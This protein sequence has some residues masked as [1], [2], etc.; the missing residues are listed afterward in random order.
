MDWDEN[1]INLNRVFSAAERDG[2]TRVDWGTG[3]WWEIVDSG[4]RERVS[5]KI[6]QINSP[7]KSSEV[8]RPQR[9]AQGERFLASL[10]K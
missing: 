4:D 9:I 2:G 5:A 8:A 3:R 7:R 6:R 1:P 10:T